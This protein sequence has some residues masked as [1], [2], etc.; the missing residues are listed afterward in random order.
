M[1]HQV[2]LLEQ[3]KFVSLESAR[4]SILEI[5]FSIIMYLKNIFKIEFF[6]IGT[7]FESHN[8]HLFFYRK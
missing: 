1:P 5:Y 2:M 7:L 8:L 3:N 4:A 6:P